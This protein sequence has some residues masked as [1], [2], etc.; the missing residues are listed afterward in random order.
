MYEGCYTKEAAVV[1]DSAFISGVGHQLAEGF[2]FATGCD[3][4]FLLYY[5]T[6]R[7]TNLL[8]LLT[9]KFLSVKR[10][11][12]NF[13]R[14]YSSKLRTPGNPDTN[15]FIPRCIPSRPL[16]IS[17]FDKQVLDYIK[18]LRAKGGTVKCSIA[19]AAAKG[20][21]VISH[22]N[23]SVLKELG[24]SLDLGKK[25]TESFLQFRGFVCDK[26]GY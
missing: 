6:Q 17:D 9:G 2:L 10:R 15:T 25:W 8:L 16:L 4:L 26:K 19:I 3:P 14:V 7:E 5:D 1:V 24:D 21:H 11:E 20:I 23:P 18:Q 13:K 12:R 22:K